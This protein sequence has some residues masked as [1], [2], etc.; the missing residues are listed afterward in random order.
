MVTPS[1]IIC[2]Y[3][4]KSFATMRGLHQIDFGDVGVFELYI[5]TCGEY[6]LNVCDCGWRVTKHTARKIDPVLM[7]FEVS[8]MAHSI[9]RPSSLAL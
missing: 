1:D 2:S 6:S 9:V 7:K 5:H 4:R 8:E 3:T